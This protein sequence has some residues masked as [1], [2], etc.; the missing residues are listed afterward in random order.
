MVASVEGEHRI[1][2]DI[3]HDR[4]VCPAIAELQRARR[5]RRSP[6]V[7]AAAGEH[8]RAGA[9]LDDGAWAG[10]RAAERVL[11]G[12]VEIEPAVVRDVAND[13][14]AR[15]LIADDQAG[16]VDRRAAGVGVVARQVDV[17]G[18]HDDAAAAG[19][20]AAEDVLVGAVEIELAVVGDV[21][22]D[23]TARALIADDQTGA[24]DR[25]A[26]GVGAV[27][28]QIHII[29]ADDDAAAARDRAAEDV[30]VAPV[31]IKLA[32]VGDVAGDR[33]ARAL[34]ADDE[35]GAVDRRAAGIGAVARQIDIVAAHSNAA[36]ARDRAAEDVLGR[37]VE[38]ECAIVRDVADDRSVRPAIAEL[39]RA[40]GDRRPPGVRVVAGENGSAGARLDNGACARDRAAERVLVGAVEIEQAVVRDAA[41]DPTA[42]TLVADDQ[43]GAVDRRAAGIGVVARQVDVVGGHDDATAARDRAAEDVLVGPVEIE[44]AAVGDV[45]GDRPARALI[46]DDQAGAVDRRAASVGAVAGQVH[47]VAADDDAA[48][49]RNRAAEDVLIAPVED[50]RAVVPDIAANRAAGSAIAQLKRARRN[51]RATAIR[52]VSEDDL[53]AACRL[54]RAYRAAVTGRSPGWSHNPR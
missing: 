24:V 5:D 29:G 23:R 34:I 41:D 38:C 3:A 14:A 18:G 22:G 11:V 39:Q 54:D 42:C 28:G 16:A 49:A 4:T 52:V 7:G 47:I 8:G 25:R 48:A 1:V 17:V 10:D 43:A 20:R 37:L 31:E 36:A 27:A 6:G 45:A 44:P 32:V 33:T 40:R 15:A 13:R 2:D 21:P 9:R 51:R 30:L 50:E 35:A 46:A 53:R 12:A 19:D 26:A